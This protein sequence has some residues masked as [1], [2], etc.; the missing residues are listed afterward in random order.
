MLS[1]RDFVHFLMK[2]NA[3][4]LKNA[5]VTPEHADD[6]PVVSE[7]G[8]NIGTFILDATC[9]PSN[10]KFMQNFLK[11]NARQIELFFKLL[12]RPKEFR[13]LKIEEGKISFTR[14]SSGE[15]AGSAQMSIGQRM[16]LAFSVMITLHIRAVNAPNF[17]M[18]DEPRLS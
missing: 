8:E 1:A 6:K 10:I 18:L 2:A 13:T 3:L 9:S 5:E 12:H 16:A 7:D 4:Y 14:I 15:P 11:E 17:I